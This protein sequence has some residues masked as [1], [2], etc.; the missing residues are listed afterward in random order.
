ME[1]TR[2]SGSG[3]IETWQP[4]VVFIAGANSVHT[5]RAYATVLRQFAGVAR[6]ELPVVTELHV[7]AFKVELV[8]AGRASSTIRHRLIIVTQFFDWAIVRGYHPG[9]NPASGIPKP[10]R[11]QAS[12]AVA[13]TGPQVERLLA[14]AQNARDRALLV[15]MA[16]AGLRVGEVVRLQ[17]RDLV[18]D[19]GRP[20]V[21]VRDGK[22]GKSR[23]VA[24][25]LR[26][27]E[28]AG[29]YL[30]EGSRVAGV[31]KPLIQALRARGTG[32][33]ERHVSRLVAEVTMQ[34]GLPAISPHDLRRTFATRALQAGCPLPLVQ[35]EMGH[36]ELS[37]TAGYYVPG[38]RGMM[39]LRERAADY[40]DAPLW[41]ALEEAVLS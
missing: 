7:V 33:T 3:W 24:L 17:E 9:P 39:V 20:V 34:A 1:L 21:I 6:V 30:E 2:W 28:L 18:T 41:S 15:L 12:T 14:A 10:K 4:A 27:V 36:G 35:A 16:D 40:L 19:A 32:L 31:S 11:R 5:R 29:Q 22:G 8:D 13:L 23:K 37:T 38:P 25:T 26:A